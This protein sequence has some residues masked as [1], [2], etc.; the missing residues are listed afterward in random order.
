MYSHDEMRQRNRK[1]RA[2]LTPQQLEQAAQELV[3]KIVTL[4]AYQQA[5][6]VAA[7]FA[8]NGEIGLNPLIDHALAAGKQVYLP[9]LDQETL[10]FSPYFREQKMRINRFRLPEPDVGDEEMLAPLQLDLVLAPLVVFDANR[11]RIGMG[12]GFYDRSFALRKNPAIDR[13]IL[14]GVAHELQKA[15]HIAPEDWD[16]QL[17]MIVTDQTVYR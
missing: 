12:G 9:N 16:V 14:I 2:A 6:H 11:N 8:V 1:L 13:P 7:Y 10:R 15:E 17:D 3:Q 4:D 5:F